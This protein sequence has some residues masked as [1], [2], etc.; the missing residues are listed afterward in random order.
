MTSYELR[1]PAGRRGTPSGLLE[2]HAVRV[3]TRKDSKCRPAWGMSAAS[4]ELKNA[5]WSGVVELSFPD[6]L[7]PKFAVLVFALLRTED[8]PTAEGDD[9]VPDHSKRSRALIASLTNRCN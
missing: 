1:G 6:L 4:P 7:L 3:G 5:V 9:L 8:E 2:C